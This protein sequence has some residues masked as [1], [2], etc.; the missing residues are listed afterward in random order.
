MRL[1]TIVM[2]GAV[3]ILCI[4]GMYLINKTAP[5]REEQMTTGGVTQKLQEARGTIKHETR[6]PEDVQNYVLSE[7]DRLEGEINQLES[8]I[9]EARSALETL[10]K[11]HSTVQ[12]QIEKDGEIRG[13]MYELTSKTKELRSYRKRLDSILRGNASS[14]EE[15]RQSNSGQSQP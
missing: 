6:S 4:M 1:S 12:E 15:E 3:L 8:R 9:F 10:I 13:M 2:A 5:L 11:S 14:E 7:I